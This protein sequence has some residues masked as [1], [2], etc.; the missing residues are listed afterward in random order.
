MNTCFTTVSFTAG[1]LFMNWTALLPGSIDMEPTLSLVS[2]IFNSTCAQLDLN[3]KDILLRGQLIGNYNSLMVTMIMTNSIA[4]GPEPRRGTC[5]PRPSSLLTHLG[6]GCN[7]SFC[8]VPTT[9]H[10][11]GKDAISSDPTLWQYDFSCFCGQPAC[12]ELL[13]WLRPDSMQGQLNRIGLCEIRAFWFGCRWHYWIY[14]SATTK[15]WHSLY[16]EI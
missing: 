5:H 6:S 3:D 16:H 12:N 13:L 7:Q 11:I 1:R 10:Y 8:T 15:Y 2:D 4:F 14:L 9:C